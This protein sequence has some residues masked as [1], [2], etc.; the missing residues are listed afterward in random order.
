MGETLST[1]TLD[2]KITKPGELSF[3]GQSFLYDGKGYFIVS[4]E[5]HYFRINADC[6]HIHLKHMKEAGL[7]TVSTYI[8]WSLHEQIEGEPDFSGRYGANLDLERF[9][10]LCKDMQMNLT[11]KPGPYILAELSMH[12]IPRWFFENYPDARAC[13][14]NGK[15]Y[16]M[17]YTCL[18]HPDYTRKAMQWYDAV[19]PLLA[20]H[21]LS[22]S[23]PIAFMQVC[24]E[25]GLFQWLGGAG[26]Y[27]PASLEDYRN[28]LQSI[29]G[30]ITRL[31]KRYKTDYQNWQHIRPPA[32]HV[33]TFA[34]HIGYRDWHTYHR[35]FYADY[36]GQL[37]N[38]IRSRGI[39]TALFHNVPGWVF[40]RAKEM[41]V[42]LSM[43]HELSR[44][45]PDIL[46]GVDHIPENLSY[47][48]F[49]DDRIINEFT[50]AVQGSSGPMYVAELQAGTREANVTVYP[51]EMELFY[52]S[53]LAN[54]VVSMNYYMFSAGQNPPGW[55]VYDSSFYLQTPLDVDGRPGKQYPV[56]KRI[57]K[58][59]KTHGSRLCNAA[60][61]A[62]QALAFYPPY[63]YRELTR[64][65]FSKENYDPRSGIDS[66][67]DPTSIT[68]ELLFDG[69]GK[70]L[71]MDNQEYDAVD[72]T[73]DN[74]KQLSH[75]K[76][77]WV[78]STDRMDA[79]SQKRLL[80]YVEDGGHL[81]CFPTLPKF[82]LQDNPCTLL[83]DGLKVK[84][85]GV[86]DD[87][88][89][90]I[91]WADSGEEIHATRYIETF[92]ADNAR[93]IALARNGQT[94]G[95]RV[96]CDKGSASI[97]GTGFMYQAVA[98][99]TAW[100]K[101]GLTED[102]RGPVLCDNPNII[103]RTREMA[104]DGGY[105]FMLN[106][107]NQPLDTKINKGIN[108][109]ADAQIHLPPCSGLILPFNMPLNDHCMLVATTS[110]ILAWESTD[111]KIILEISGHPKTQ[112]QM[113][114]K[115]NHEIRRI[116]LDGNTIAQSQHD[117]KITV[118]F[119]HPET[120][121]QLVIHFQPNTI[122]SM[123]IHK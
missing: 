106:Y 17:Q 120:P 18:V 89:G 107:H 69:V 95:L 91:R 76:Q 108:E 75:Y 115:C 56:V 103:T 60:T 30:D 12:G 80:D 71:A 10:G 90:M 92:E 105:L 40:S 112:G 2:E 110:E 46:L 3:D 59:I 99:R 77:L 83:A 58:L 109:L 98:H 53:C 116:S 55:S 100:Q 81:I 37:I 73:R 84:S 31:N 97:F 117:P 21:Q 87:F 1:D 44:L 101:L 39:T 67:L 23:G 48:N 16:P 13:D 6:W 123:E 102:F 64:P 15:P 33:K 70:L 7:N 114:L 28:Y 50:K 25:V 54:G 20:R 93:T 113:T 29:Y 41:P 4:G 119:Q 32:G 121:G 11:V 51:S 111:Q 19:M 45:Y 26:D 88:D 68:D 34:D 35:H 96:H 61:N 78:A 79:A 24:N 74:S 27:S 85:S 63:Y 52:K 82:D 86:L 49:H 36:I 43:Y 104:S 9:I 62:S 72:I 22:Q 42:C 47:R 66:R 118:R 94:C 8:P 5:M 14:A 38:E 122:Q 57:G 65:L